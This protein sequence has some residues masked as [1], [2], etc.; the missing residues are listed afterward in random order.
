MLV[1]FHQRLQT[2]RAGKTKTKIVDIIFYIIRR[3][4]GPSPAD[5]HKMSDDAM[6]ALALNV[7]LIYSTAWR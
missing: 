4:P 6:T 2:Q 5:T 1:S 3:V 7:L